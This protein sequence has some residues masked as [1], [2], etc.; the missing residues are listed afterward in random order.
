MPLVRLMILMFMRAHLSAQLDE[1]RVARKI[2]CGLLYMKRGQVDEELVFGNRTHSPACETFCGMIG[3]TVELQGF[4]GFAGGLD[5]K[6]ACFLPH[7]F[8]SLREAKHSR[9]FR[10]CSRRQHG[11]TLCLYQIAQH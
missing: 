11:N 3:K 7:W 8:S 10:G 5:T 2:K 6:R 9:C 1:V 4:K